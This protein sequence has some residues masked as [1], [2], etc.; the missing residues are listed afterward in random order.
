MLYMK[1]M[2]RERI[3]GRKALPEHEVKAIFREMGLAVPKG[4][5][6]ERGGDIPPGPD[7]AYPL[8]AKI[9]SEKVGS[10][11]DVGGV[12]LGILDERTLRQ[13]VRELFAGGQAEGVLVEEMLPPGLEVIV[14]GIIDRQF[15]PVVMFGPGGIHV[16]VFRD[17]AFALAPLSREDGQWLIRQVKGRTLL[18]G[19]RG[20][21]AV[22]RE[23]LLQVLMAVSRIMATEEVE[24]IDLNPVALYPDRAV[25]LDAKMRLLSHW[26][27]RSKDL[28]DGSAL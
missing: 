7:L 15:G 17:T 27:G 18:D 1:P 6:I 9:S 8:V 2:L 10:K 24:E 28:H 22:D 19:F 26:T 21:P 3:R 25:I 20:R 13:H 11:S 12:R 14:G 23:A 16:E 4:V 5:Y